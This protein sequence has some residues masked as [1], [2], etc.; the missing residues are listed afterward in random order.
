MGSEIARKKWHRYW[1]P[2]AMS[3][4][5]DKDFATLSHFSIETLEIKHARNNRSIAFATV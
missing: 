2:V 1:L 5:L 4:L 3:F